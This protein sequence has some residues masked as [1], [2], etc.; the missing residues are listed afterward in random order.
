MD[1]RQDSALDHPIWAALTG[2][3]SSMAL[4]YGDARR[5]DDELS[6]LAALQEPTPKAFEDLTHLVPIEGFVGLFTLADVA[7]PEGWEL[8]RDGWLDQMIFEGERPSLPTSP[9]LLTEADV[10]EMLTLT[11]ATE[12][13]P[14][15]NR[16][17]EFGR[18]FGIRSEDGRLI[19]LTGE[20]IRV[21]EFTEVS[22]VCTDPEFRGQGHAA[23]LISAVVAH[24]LDDGRIPMLHVLPENQAARGLYE[25]LGFRSRRVLRLT[26]VTR[27]T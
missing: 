25:K 22:A 13:G 9:L 24:I 23:T 1:P 27:T 16:T 4:A 14:F 19:S 5:Y 20:R 11:A 15:R 2:E 18:Y 26:V 12:P 3:Q 6:P 8:A 17:I 7:I 21:G 10:P